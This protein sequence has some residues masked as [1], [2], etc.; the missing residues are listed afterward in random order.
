MV[1]KSLKYLFRTCLTI[2]MFNTILW[3]Y[4]FSTPRCKLEYLV[5]INIIILTATW[6]NLR[7]IAKY[8]LREVLFIFI[9]CIPARCI[10]HVNYVLSYLKIS[11]RCNINTLKSTK[12]SDVSTYTQVCWILV[13]NKPHTCLHKYTSHYLLYIVFIVADAS[14][15]RDCINLHEISFQLFVCKQV[16]NIYKL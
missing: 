9:V 2:I 3:W 10:L 16:Y 6:I 5:L 4:I 1:Y 12:V 13:M 15:G 14:V 11:V 8:Y 7:R